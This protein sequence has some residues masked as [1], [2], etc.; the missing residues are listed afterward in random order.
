MAKSDILLEKIRTHV[1]LTSKEKVMLIVLLSIPSILAQMSS[2]IMFYIDA[3]MVG[4][5]GAQASA[6]IGII[7]TT[8]WLLGGLTSAVSMGFSVQVAHCIGAN[9][10]VRARAIMRQSLLCG[11]VVSFVLSIIGL[12]IHKQLPIWLGAEK[13]IVYDASM[14]F[15]IFCLGIPFMQLEGI[16]SSMLKCAGDM[17]SP[18]YMNI[19]A[20]VLDVV[21]NYFFIFI[22]DLGVIGSALGT[23]CAFMVTAIIILYIMLF[24]NK[25]LSLRNEHGSF[26]PTNENILQAAKIGVPIALQRTIMSMAQMVSTIIVAPLGT[27]AIA[28][29]SLSITAESVC[30]MPGYGVQDA[31]TT[32]IGQSYGAGQKSLAKN[33]AYMSVIGGILTMTIMGI[34]MFIFAPEMIGLMSPVEE[35]QKLGSQVLRIEAFAEPMF[36][37]SIVVYG[38][39]VGVGKTLYPVIINAFCMWGI[40]LTLAALLAK[41]FGLC[42]VWIAMAIELTVR[43][44]IHLILLLRGNWLK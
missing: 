29:H 3:A 38:I 21:F 9:D 6:S 2:I 41:D 34:L 7:E 11:I 19:L 16:A 25:L 20:C 36:A 17:K 14:Y 43:G 42:G 8:I 44:I 40:R 30:Y 24:K 4:H 31:A 12:C 10:F 37:A 22:M 26:K 1:D 13:D 32:L 23:F 39:F 27:I 33:L 28:A 5:L 35:I 15:M 18:S